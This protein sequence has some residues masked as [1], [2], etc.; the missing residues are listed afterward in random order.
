MLSF[1]IIWVSSILLSMSSFSLVPFSSAPLFSV[2]LPTDLF[3]SRLNAY[4]SAP[5]ESLT[6]STFCFMFSRHAFSLC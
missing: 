5:N 1:F 4:S 6:A 3:A 2:R